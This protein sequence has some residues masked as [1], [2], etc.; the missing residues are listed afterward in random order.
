[1]ACQS[2]SYCGV[3]VVDHAWFFT[4]AFWS[5][6]FGA[7]HDQAMGSG[8]SVSSRFLTQLEINHI[9]TILY[10]L[11]EVGRQEGKPD[12]EPL[13]Q[14]AFGMYF[15]GH[16]AS[17][18]AKYL[19]IEKVGS[20]LLHCLI[21]IA[22]KFRWEESYIFPLPRV[23]LIVSENHRNYRVSDSLFRFYFYSG[24]L[25]FCFLVVVKTSKRAK[26]DFVAQ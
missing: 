17:M 10:T 9:L 20:D 11:V 21:L 2:P 4:D 6:E 12:G 8:E 16:Q 24:N 15:Q 1:M 3:G 26:M 22:T 7:F 13:I 5:R 23:R 19:H 18:V 25:F 14:H